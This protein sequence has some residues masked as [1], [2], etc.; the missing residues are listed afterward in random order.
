MS[1]SKSLAIKK[2]TEILSSLCKQDPKHVISLLVNREVSI[3]FSVSKK[4]QNDIFVAE[5]IDLKIHDDAKVTLF[6]KART[7]HWENLLKEDEE[8]FIQVLS[9][10]LEFLVEEP[11]T[12]EDFILKEK[13]H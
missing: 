11:D 1:F 13:R 4:D 5:K 9:P 3:L 10:I 8:E 6:Y 7:K 12:N 2:Q